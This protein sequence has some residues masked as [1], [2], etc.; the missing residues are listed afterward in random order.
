MIAK[1]YSLYLTRPTE[2]G[3]AVPT[4]SYVELEVVLKET[5][6]S[7]AATGGR[8]AEVVLP[9]MVPPGGGGQL[10]DIEKV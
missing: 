2:D 1:V 5:D 6:C 8:P 9:A 7:S 4:V 10:L 3:P